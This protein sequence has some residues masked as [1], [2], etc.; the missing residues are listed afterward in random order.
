MEGAREMGT[1][2]KKSRSRRSK[3]KNQHPTEVVATSTITLVDLF[4]DIIR[5][6]HPTNHERQGA[7]LLPDAAPHRLTDCTQ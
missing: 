3:T 7:K 4:M 6:S 2:R 5:P 1:R